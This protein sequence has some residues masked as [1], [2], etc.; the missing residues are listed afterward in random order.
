MEGFPFTQNG[1]KDYS[2]K[3]QDSGGQKDEAF[4]WKRKRDTDVV[5]LS[6]SMDLF[7]FGEEVQP[8]TTIKRFVTRLCFGISFLLLFA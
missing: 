3:G 1:T 4:G 6:L 7:C 2:I 5:D 8:V